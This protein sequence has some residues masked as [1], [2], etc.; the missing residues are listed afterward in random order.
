MRIIEGPPYISTLPSHYLKTPPKIYKKR[1]KRIRLPYFTVSVFDSTSMLST[2]DF[3]G[4]P[5]K[6]QV[7]KRKVSK[8]P[9]SK[10]PVSKCQVYKTS[11]FKT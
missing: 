3:Y 7:S 4:T 9:V 8:R 1:K 11:G 5:T 2:K 10:R 6:R